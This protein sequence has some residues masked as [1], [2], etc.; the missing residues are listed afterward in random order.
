MAKP[1]PSSVSFKLLTY[2]ENKEKFDSKGVS[3]TNV[4]DAETDTDV[5]TLL[6]LN[7]NIQRLEEKMADQKTC[8]AEI[9]KI[10]NELLLKYNDHV[11]SLEKVKKELQEKIDKQCAKTPGSNP[12]TG[13]NPPID[14]NIPNLSELESKINNY[15]LDIK[16][17]FN[18]LKDLNKTITD[19]SVTSHSDKPNTA[20]GSNLTTDQITQIN[21]LITEKCNYDDK[22]TDL[23]KQT[24]EKRDN[25]KKAVEGTIF[26]TQKL[27]LAN[28]AQEVYSYPIPNR[29]HYNNLTRYRVGVK[30]YEE[31]QTK[32]RNLKTK[33]LATQNIEESDK[34]TPELI[35]LRGEFF[36]GLYSSFIVAGT[37]NKELR[38]MRNRVRALEGA[39]HLILS[40]GPGPQ[41]I[42]ENQ[43][44]AMTMT[45]NCR[46]NKTLAKLFGKPA[47]TLF[48]ENELPRIYLRNLENFPKEKLENSGIIRLDSVS[49]MFTE[50]VVESLIQKDHGITIKFAGRDYFFKEP[51]FEFQSVGFWK[52]KPLKPFYLGIHPDTCAVV[53]YFNA[54][55]LK[56]DVQIT[57]YIKFKIKLDVTVFG[58]GIF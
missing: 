52:T 38:I 28:L 46:L 2:N 23:Q 11:A 20:G 16:K 55:I 37:I 47:S 56:P 58:Q 36:S 42:Q 21:G 7:K 48:Y 4:G 22:I 33:I 41:L 5:V 15:E 51:D 8:C 3:I 29:D 27:L 31:F 12:P 10:S 6:I 45:F 30:T 17:I 53:E 35:E 57:D 39:V 1:P 54:V 26:N 34:L 50:D 32:A 19:I 25:L 44:T 43:Q 40:K 49:I 13:S 18:Q 24:D 14:S 9:N